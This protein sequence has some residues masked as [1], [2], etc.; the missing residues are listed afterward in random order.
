MIEQVE[1]GGED[2]YEVCCKIHEAQIYLIKFIV[3]RTIIRLI[4]HS[5]VK[6]QNR[7]GC[8]CSHSYPCC[9][10][11]KYSTTITTTTKTTT[12]TTFLVLTFEFW[13]KQNN[14]TENQTPA[15][16]PFQR[17]HIPHFR[18]RKAMHRAP[19]ADIVRQLYFRFQDVLWLPV[20]ESR[21]L[22]L[23]SRYR[24]VCG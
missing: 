5:K 7:I 8:H 2:V 22:I 11:N 3:Q 12:T 23:T 24:Q 6:G 21:W 18:C 1:I 17:S 15:S 14:P 16:P 10:C 4:I 19:H 9:L 20:A 13:V